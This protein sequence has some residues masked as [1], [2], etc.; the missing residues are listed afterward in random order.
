MSHAEAILFA[1]L[2]LVVATLYLFVLVLRSKVRI[3]DMRAATL[4][5]TVDALGDRAEFPRP[6]AES[7]PKWPPEGT[8]A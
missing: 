6:T 7:R 3:L 1:L 4:E 8:L 2:L 5:R